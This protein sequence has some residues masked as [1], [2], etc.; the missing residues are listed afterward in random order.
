MRT[1]ANIEERKKRGESISPEERAF[2]KCCRLWSRL[3]A[4][5]CDVEDVIDRIE[6][7]TDKAR[8]EEHLNK[9]KLELEECQAEFNPVDAELRERY[10]D[11]RGADSLGPKSAAKVE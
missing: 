3:L 5:A 7:Y 1:H 6:G 9:L 4:A 8:Y 2:A 10:R 11:L